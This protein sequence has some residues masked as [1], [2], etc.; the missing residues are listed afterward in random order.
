MCVCVR[1]AWWAGQR[2]AA[3]QWWASYKVRI[4]QSRSFRYYNNNMVGRCV[5]VCAPPACCSCGSRRVCVRDAAR[6]S[7]RP[8]L[9][10]ASQQDTPIHT[11]NTPCPAPNRA[12]RGAFEWRGVRLL[13]VL[14]IYYLISL[15]GR[16]S[17]RLKHCS[18][19]SQM[20][21]HTHTYTR[22]ARVVWWWWCESVQATRT[23]TMYRERERDRS[24]SVCLCD[25]E[26]I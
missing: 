6:I 24:M 16:L 1:G 2:A 19:G 8:P 10:A 11:H 26:H 15:C 25:V 4:A 23:K 20:H 18:K 7:T 14:G 22:T 17:G 12:W 5:P 9:T 21:I 3:H 13:F